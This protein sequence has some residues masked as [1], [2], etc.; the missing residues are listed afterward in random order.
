MA[1]M[2]PESRSTER[3]LLSVRSPRSAHKGL[4]FIFKHLIN[5]KFTVRK[6]MMYPDPWKLTS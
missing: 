5:D 2:G 4:L 1:E 3:L 6:N